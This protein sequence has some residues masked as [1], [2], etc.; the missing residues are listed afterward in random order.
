MI[1]S[2]SSWSV[3]GCNS[4]QDH[5]RGLG[6]STV[7][8]R[9]YV[10]NVFYRQ[11]PWRGTTHGGTN[12]PRPFN[13]ASLICVACLFACLV[14]QSSVSWLPGGVS[15]HTNL[16]NCCIMSQLWYNTRGTQAD[17]TEGCRSE[18][19]ELKLRRSIVREQ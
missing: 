17:G 12:E 2:C 13:R 11:A 8:L 5:A 1:R 6:P 10:T 9:F 16:R 14:F 3:T 4:K 7:P 15:I 19:E 18:D